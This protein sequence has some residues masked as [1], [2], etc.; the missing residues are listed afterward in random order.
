MCAAWSGGA[1]E[2]VE[3]LAKF[4][5]IPTQWLVTAQVKREEKETAAREKEVVKMERTEM[6]LIQKLKK[7]QVMQQQAFEDLE[8]ALNGDLAALGRSVDAGDS[9][10]EEGKA[11]PR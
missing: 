8:Q 4:G 3:A 5:D 10:A 9:D 1:P 11:D 2:A 7:T 6:Q